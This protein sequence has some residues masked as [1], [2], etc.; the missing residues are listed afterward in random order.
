[1]VLL[2]ASSQ[3]LIFYLLHLPLTVTL[4]NEIYQGAELR[5]AQARFD[6]NSNDLAISRSILSMIFE[7][8]KHA[9]VWRTITARRLFP[10]LTYMYEACS[11]L[12]HRVSCFTKPQ[13]GDLISFPLT[14]KIH[15][16]LFRWAQRGK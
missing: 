13:A 16:S 4:L 10:S 5:K 2:K 12:Y 6:N 11:A 14:T 8:S 1:M 15:L 9:S 3:G 7:G